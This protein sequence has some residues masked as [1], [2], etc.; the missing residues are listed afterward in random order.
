MPFP[1]KDPETR[2]VAPAGAPGWRQR[3]LMPAAAPALLGQRR[4]GGRDGPDR[5]G[6][7]A[8]G[9]EQNGPGGSA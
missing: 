1:G 7:A 6:R 4:P 3:R 8:A 2:P 5:S 9:R